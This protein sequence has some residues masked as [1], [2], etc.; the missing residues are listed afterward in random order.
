MVIHVDDLRK[1][2]NYQGFQDW[3]VAAGVPPKSFSSVLWEYDKGGALA[4]FAYDG[5]DVVGQYTL[6]PVT[7]RYFGKDVK[8]AIC[9]D[10]AV[11]PDY[12][13]KGLFTRMGNQAMLKAKF[14]NI[15]FVYGFPNEQALPGHLGAGWKAIGEVPLMERVSPPAYNTRVTANF[16]RVT[17]IPFTFQPCNVIAR[18]RLSGAE[19][20]YFERPGVQYD[21]YVTHGGWFVLKDYWDEGIGRRKL[22]LIDWMTIDNEFDDIVRF[23]IKEAFERRA[24]T[25]ITTCNW[26]SK[27]AKVLR[28]HGFVEKHA[29]RQFIVRKISD[30]VDDRLY[31]LKNYHL[32]MGDSDVF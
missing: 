29:G 11:H 28:E 19:W 22:H 25:A 20:R 31:D 8:A 7:W 2:E 21:V 23:Y 30:N 26:A 12:R 13:G 1:V 3:R 10:I 6:R 5:N 15:D 4:S 17:S 14:N 27:D 32:T 16:R 18:D 9:F 24:D